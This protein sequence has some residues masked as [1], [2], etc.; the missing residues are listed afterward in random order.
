[1]AMPNISSVTAKPT[2]HRC[3]SRVWG[4]SFWLKE[5]DINRYRAL[6][7]RVSRAISRYPPWEAMRV[8]AAYCPAEAFTK[9]LVR[10]AWKADR[11]AFLAVI[12]RVK[13]TAR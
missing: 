10:V 5:Q 7:T 9:K 12:P 8:K 6:V 2:V 3:H 13:D 4:E 1:M 11:P